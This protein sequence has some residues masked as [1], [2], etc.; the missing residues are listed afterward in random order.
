M[1]GELLAPQDSDATRRELCRR[2]GR[3][4]QWDWDQPQL[5][6]FTE[7]VDWEGVQRGDPGLWQ[8]ATCATCGRE[9]RRVRVV[10]LRSGRVIQ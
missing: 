7:C 9:R 4:C 5:V 8:G 1:I 6:P 2:A 3:I 10:N